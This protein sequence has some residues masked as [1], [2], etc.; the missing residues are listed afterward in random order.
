MSEEEDAILCEDLDRSDLSKTDRILLALQDAL[1]SDEFVESQEAFADRHC[2]LFDATG[3]LPPQCMAIYREYVALVE[4]KLQQKVQETAPD[5][6]FE[7]LLPI[8]LAHKSGEELAF[9][10]V[11]EILNA[12]IDFAEFRALMASYKRGR[13][14][15]FD[16]RA[17]KL[18]K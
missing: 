15:T 5:F 3:D 6:D 4:A 10:E 2:D 11:F 13:D 8:V 1:T 18:Q 14:L 12:T 9:A 7:E 17:V 16:V